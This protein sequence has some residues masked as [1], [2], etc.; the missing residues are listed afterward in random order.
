MEIGEGVS[1]IRDSKSRLIRPMVFALTNKLILMALLTSIFLALNVPFSV[2]TVVA[3]YGFCQLFFYVSP[4]P[5]GIGVVETIF[6]VILNMLTVPLAAGL[7]ITLIYRALTVW[8]TFGVGFWSFRKLQQ[9]YS[10]EKQTV[11][12]E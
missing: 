8:L 1:T 2:G 6:P 7:L 12:V 3:G 4:T 10:K 5:A 11:P 9:S